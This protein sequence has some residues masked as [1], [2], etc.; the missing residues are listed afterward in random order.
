MMFAILF[1]SHAATPPLY[2]INQK[3]FGCIIFF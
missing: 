2:K 3:F 1:L